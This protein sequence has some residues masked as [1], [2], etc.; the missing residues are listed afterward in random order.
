MGGAHNL[1][2]HCLGIPM[3]LLHHDQYGSDDAPKLF[4]I[5]WD[6]EVNL[7]IV[8]YFFDVTHPRT[9]IPDGN[10]KFGGLFAF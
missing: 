7:G 4:R 1:L 6:S 3:H 5:Y 2:V 10:V 8:F 9:N